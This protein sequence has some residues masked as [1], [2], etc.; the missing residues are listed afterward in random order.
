MRRR[1]IDRS[2]TFFEKLNECSWKVTDY[3]LVMIVDIKWPSL[4][5]KKQLLDD[6]GEIE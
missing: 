4:N 5:I 1:A 3:K 2:F 6:K